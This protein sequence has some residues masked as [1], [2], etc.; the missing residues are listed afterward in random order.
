MQE[1]VE[2]GVGLPK[3]IPGRTIQLSGRP[4]AYAFW[5]CVA[6]VACGPPLTGSVRLHSYGKK[7]VGMR[8]T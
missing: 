3:R 1:G 5:G 8:L 4:T 7:K 6:F 2:M